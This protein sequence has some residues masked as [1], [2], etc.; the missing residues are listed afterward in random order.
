MSNIA[1]LTCQRLPELFET[2]RTLIPLFQQRGIYAEP[3]VWSDPAIDWKKYDAL[4]IRNTWDYYTQGDAFINWLKFIRDNNIT[5]LNPAEVVL[6]N[7]HKFYLR[8]FEQQGIRIIPT[9]FSDHSAPATLDTIKQRGWSKIVIKPAISAGSYETNTY[10]A[11]VLAP[12]ALNELLS[13]NDWLIQP[14][15]PEIVQGELSMIFFNGEFSHAAIKKPADG[16]FRV[17]RQYGGKYQLINPTN[18]LVEVARKIIAQIPQQ[19]LYARVD[20]VMINEEFHLMELELIE[21]DLYFELDETIKTRFV[22]AV[23]THIK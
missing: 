11:N 9:I 8:D 3:A 2:D 15:L 5:M 17:Q 19:L 1:L 4:V 23:A 16:E 14:F 21:P 12:R 22:S 18:D 13:G 20:G 7:V 6:Q 10:D